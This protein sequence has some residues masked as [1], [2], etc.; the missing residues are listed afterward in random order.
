[1]IN[2]DP[3]IPGVRGI[4]SGGLISGV[5]NIRNLKFSDVKQC[6]VMHVIIRITYEIH[7]ST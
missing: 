6:I 3:E 7:Y 2:M 5:V 4:S 1:M